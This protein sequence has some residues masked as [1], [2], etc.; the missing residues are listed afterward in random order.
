MRWPTKARRVELG[1]EPDFLHGGYI[2]LVDNRFD[3]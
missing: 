2:D 3:P 1:N